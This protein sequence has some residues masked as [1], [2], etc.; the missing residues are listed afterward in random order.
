MSEEERVL[1][2][3]DREALQGEWDRLR[4]DLPKGEAKLANFDPIEGRELKEGSADQ[5]KTSITYLGE[6]AISNIER[7]LGIEKDAKLDPQTGSE[8]PMEPE[9]RLGVLRSLASEEV[10]IA[11]EEEGLAVPRFDSETGEAIPQD[12]LRALS[13]VRRLRRSSVQEGEMADVQLGLTTL[14]EM[15]KMR[16][17]NEKY[18]KRLGLEKS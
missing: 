3:E 8:L 5:L 11:R 9:K 14:E 12:S 17:R 1:S 16:A 18:R 6:I 4:F 13:E 10:R 2:P 7:S 15:R